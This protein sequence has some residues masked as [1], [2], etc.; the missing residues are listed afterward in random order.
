MRQRMFEE[1]RAD[2]AVGVKQLNQGQSTPFTNEVLR[3]VK[4]N[5]RK[6]VR[7]AGTKTA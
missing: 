5:G 2:L 7:P 1:L 3:R 6:R 4:D